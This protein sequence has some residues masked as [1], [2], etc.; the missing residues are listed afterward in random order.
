MGLTATQQMDLD[1]LMYRVGV[2]E[3]LSVIGVGCNF[4]GAVGPIHKAHCTYA[5]YTR[6]SFV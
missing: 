3:V 2:D 6:R 4:C 5:R 1:K